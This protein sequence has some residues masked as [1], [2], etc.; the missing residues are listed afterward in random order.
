MLRPFVPAQDFDQ[1][2]RFYLAMGFKL[3]HADSNVAIITDGD[4]TFILQN[5][6]VRDLA[7]NLM[8]QLVVDDVEAW[9]A[10]RNP[11]RLSEAFSTG[12]PTAPTLQPWGMKV[13]YIQ[14]PSGVL[15]HVTELPAETL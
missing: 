2:K 1:S 4:V 11:E 10:E 13:G 12:S 5:F 8:L 15:W 6:Y 9:W 7:E 3:G 14:D